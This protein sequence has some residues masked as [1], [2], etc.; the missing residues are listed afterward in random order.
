MCTKNLHGLLQN[1][2]MLSC[3]AMMPL[4]ADNYYSV[5]L[6]GQ[7]LGYIPDK[8]AKNIADQLR[9][10]KVK[11]LNEVNKFHLFLLFINLFRLCTVQ[12]L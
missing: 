5:L 11:Q 9:R 2:G 8:K 3:A 10:M 7:L 1:L 6:N 12:S 4:S